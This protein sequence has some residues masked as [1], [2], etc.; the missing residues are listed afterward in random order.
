[1]RAKKRRNSNPW[2]IWTEKRKNAQ[3]SKGQNIS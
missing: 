2:R 1:L 3:Y